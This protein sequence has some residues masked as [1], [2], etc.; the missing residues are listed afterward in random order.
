MSFSK[1]QAFSEPKLFKALVKDFLQID[2]FEISEVE[3]DKAFY[4]V[5]GNVNFKF[6]LFAEDSKN[7]IIV[8]MQHAHYSD[9]YERFLYYQCC[10]MIESVA[11]SQNYSFP[12]TVNTLVFFTHKPTPSPNS[13]ILEVD[14]QAR[15]TYD[16]KVIEK[17][18]GKRKHRLLFVYVKDYN[19]AYSSEECAEWM[20]AFHDTLDS[21]V[22]PDSYE[23]PYIG[24][25]FELIKEDKITPDE[26][27]QMKKENNQEEAQKDARQEGF[28]EGEKKGLKEGERK[29][30]ETTRN[31]LA[32]GSLSVEQI[33]RATGLPLERVKALSDRD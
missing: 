11:S 26:R 29:I 20:E 15:D 2:G 24:E 32:M 17:V 6:D 16:G 22:S 1:K 25:M 18:F 4:P 8:E 3:N 19:G 28:K 21:Q 5:V 31:L 23:N 12:I 9:T 30:A 33:A 14:F 13:G 10:A 7:R 27:A